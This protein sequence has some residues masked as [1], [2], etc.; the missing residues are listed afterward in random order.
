MAAV[1]TSDYP[2]L[3]K[4]V[5]GTP[6]LYVEISSAAVD[7]TFD[8][9]GTAAFSFTLPTAIFTQTAGQQ[10]YLTS[11]DEAVCAAQPL[12]VGISTVLGPLHASGNTL[13]LATSDP[14]FNFIYRAPSV[15]APHGHKV[16]ALIYASPD[17]PE[18]QSRHMDS[19]GRVRIA[20]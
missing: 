3:L 12:S 20:R 15:V 13:T 9:M 4:V 16:L 17:D 6:I 19:N 7:L 5:D 14:L 2:Q 10:Y 8:G 1:A 18:L 11:C